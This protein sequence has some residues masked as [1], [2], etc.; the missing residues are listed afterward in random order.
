MSVVKVFVLSPGSLSSRFSIMIMPADGQVEEDSARY[1]KAVSNQHRPDRIR[2][3]AVVS[4]HCRFS[5]L[6]LSPYMLFLYD[7]L[8]MSSEDKR[9]TS[10]LRAVFQVNV[11]PTVTVVVPDLCGLFR[12][13]SQLTYCCTDGFSS[14]KPSIY[15]H[16]IELITHITDRTVVRESIKY[17]EEMEGSRRISKQDQVPEVKLC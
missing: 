10:F 4:D 12:F 2:H 3:I 8:L 13:Q 6:P 11:F 7:S 1:S 9:S 5:L 16:V 17:P 15:K 14:G